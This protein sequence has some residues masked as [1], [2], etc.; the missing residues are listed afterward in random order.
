MQSQ[1]VCK[2][3]TETN[4]KGE[5]MVAWRATVVAFEVIMFSST[6][7]RALPRSHNH[8][9]SWRELS[10]WNLMTAEVHKGIT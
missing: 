4:A 5:S 7:L 2:I 8:Y 6:V 3:H 10:C 1:K 9:S